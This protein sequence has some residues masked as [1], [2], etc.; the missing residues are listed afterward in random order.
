MKTLRIAKIGKD[1]LT[2]TLPN[3]FVFNTD[4]NTPKIIAEGIDTPTLSTTA[5][6]TFRDIAHGR[7]YTP[8]VIGF[9][10]F[11]SGKVGLIGEQADNADFWCTNLR[12]NATN[13][14]FGYFN[15]TGGNY[16]PSF[17]YYVTEIPLAGTPN[18]AQISGNRLII[19]KDGYDALEET[20]PNNL[21]YDSRY[22]TF[23]YF[24]EGIKTITVPSGTPA[25]GVDLV[26]TET[27]YT[28]G[29]GY[30]PFFNAN[31]EFN[32]VDPGK[33]YICP[34]NFADAGVWG[35]EFLYMTNNELTFKSI[36]GNV[37][38]GITHPSYQVKIYYKIYSKN[39]GF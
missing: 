11:A 35:R 30:Y 16:T 21:I 38:G 7:N 14:R 25:A 22:G 27:V 26:H 32:V 23:K 3:D 12:V 9:C 8:F 5:S 33:L 36:Q 34:T 31:I 6:E 20:N 28:H 29:L 18:I 19:A 4:Y 15:N 10:K 17:K 13:I 2:A 39:L 24:V 1:A 37:F